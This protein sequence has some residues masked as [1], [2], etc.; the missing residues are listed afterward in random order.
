MIRMSD[1]RAAYAVYAAAKTKTETQYF[2]L[3]EQVALQQ[4]DGVPFLKEVACYTAGAYDAI[5]AFAMMGWTRVVVINQG[6]I[7]GNWDYVVS[8]DGMKWYLAKQRNLYPI[9][10]YSYMITPQVVYNFP[11]EKS[12]E[13]VEK[14]ANAFLWED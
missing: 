8:S 10:G 4:T 12:T 3:P 6:D 14:A 5:Q 1:E 13:Y 11:V 2:L 7:S 9:R